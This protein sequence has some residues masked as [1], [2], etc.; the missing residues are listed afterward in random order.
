MPLQLGSDGV[1]VFDVLHTALPNAT[2]GRR[3]AAGVAPQETEPKSASR[4][5][6]L[7]TATSGYAQPD[8]RDPRLCCIRDTV[9]RH[10]RIV[11][12]MLVS[13]LRRPASAEPRPP[14]CVSPHNWWC[15]P[16]Q[17]DHPVRLENFS[18]TSGRGSVHSDDWSFAGQLIAQFEPL[19]LPLGPT[20]LRLNIV[21]PSRLGNAGGDT[22]RRRHAPAAVSNGKNFRFGQ[23][24]PLVGLGAEKQG[25][26]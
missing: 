22:A 14:R 9:G 15:R 12:T 20:V 13:S 6:D 18:R 23:R 7:I 8:S 16:G 19:T 4:R 11:A 10:V 17:H 24:L 5:Y 3:A 1:P 2:S 25:D 26:Q 21:M